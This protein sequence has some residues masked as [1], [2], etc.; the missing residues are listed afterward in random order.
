[1]AGLAFAGERLP[2][3]PAAIDRALAALSVACSTVGREMQA[4]QDA[5]LA[6][7]Y[8]ALRHRHWTDSRSPL[9]YSHEQEDTPCLQL[10]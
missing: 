3:S 6:R 4:L 8:L 10:P 7:D 1:M 2:A 5:Q 9:P